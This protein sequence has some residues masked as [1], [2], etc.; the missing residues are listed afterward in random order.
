[1]NPP[2]GIPDDDE[3]D[4]ELTVD[5]EIEI[6]KRID[7]LER[8]M[9]SEENQTS[10]SESETEYDRNGAYE[11]LRSKIITILDYCIDECQKNRCP[12][13]HPDLEKI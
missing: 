11:K 5:N 9:S 2:H 10:D 13:P 7:M 3:I 8:F 4:N 1:M 6:D 12:T